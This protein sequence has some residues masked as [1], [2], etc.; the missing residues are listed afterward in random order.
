MSRAAFT[1]ADYKKA[2][3]F[4]QNLKACTTGVDGVV[5]VVCGEH[6]WPK[7][8]AQQAGALS[9]LQDKDPHFEKLTCFVTNDQD[10]VPIA[11]TIGCNIQEA[12]NHYLLVLWSL[13]NVEAIY[14]ADAQKALTGLRAAVLEREGVALQGEI[15]EAAA[16]LQAKKPLNLVQWSAS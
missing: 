13:V 14:E 4:L 11:Y 15:P 3:A 10:S 8:T 9:E 16:A 7:L 6:G 2:G 1:K 12:F 5:T